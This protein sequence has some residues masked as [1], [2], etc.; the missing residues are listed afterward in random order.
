MP[1][2]YLG[3]R[4]CRDNKDKNVIILFTTF[5]ATVCSFD[6]SLIYLIMEYRH[7]ASYL[8]TIVVVNIM[9]EHHRLHRSA[10]V[11]CMHLT[12]KYIKS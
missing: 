4:S 11:D 10:F 3:Q 2:G 7:I 1:I 8:A 12:S 5:F 9:E 6:V